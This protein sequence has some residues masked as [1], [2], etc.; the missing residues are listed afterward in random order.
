MTRHPVR[1]PQPTSRHPE[2]RGDEAAADPVVSARPSRRVSWLVVIS[3]AAGTVLFVAAVRHVGWQEML[4]GIRRVGWGFFTVVALGGLRFATRALAWMACVG[5]PVRLRFRTAFEVVL[6]S[7][8]LGTLTPAGP[9]ASEPAKVVF[10][11]GGLPLKAALPSVAIENI[12]Y[13][14]SAGLMIATGAVVLLQ[15]AALQG[16]MRTASALA[17]AGFGAVAIV[18]IALARTSRRPVRWMAGRVDRFPGGPRL[19]GWL[20]S[21]I[22]L[23]DRTLGFAADRPWRWLA[24]FLLEV[25]FHAL[26]VVEVWLTLRWILPAGSHPSLLGAFVLES[27]NRLITVVFKFVPLRVGVDELGTGAVTTLLALGPAAGV[28]LAVIRKGRTLCWTAVGVALLL[29]RG[30]ITRRTL[31]A[32]PPGGVRPLIAT[33]GGSR[34]GHSRSD[35]V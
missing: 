11:S 26:A 5:G 3:S 4:D 2:P 28:T 19:A 34:S 8:A 15:T 21:L 30:W 23:E 17:A 14:L 12:L 33:S 35:P 24:V 1:E 18:L 13:T 7:D 22:D 9:L 10:V 32:L 16:S 6:A 29:R 31:A 20:R 25:G 27:T